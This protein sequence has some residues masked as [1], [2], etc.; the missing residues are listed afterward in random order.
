MEV[1]EIRNLTKKF[2][3]KTII[4]NMSLTVNEG[5]IYGF[6]GPNGSG[7]T[8]VIKCIMGLLK[9]TKGDVFVC[10]HSVKKNYEKAAELFGGII[11]NPE[12]YG[13]LKGKT[14]LKVFSTLYPNVTAERIEE[15]GKL[16]GLEGRL[17][18]P[19]KK[20]SLGMRQRLGLAL[21]LVHN[22]KLLILDEPT[23]GLDPKGVKE[24]R[25]ILKKLAK[26][27]TAIFISSHLL[28]EM[29]L[30]CDKVCIIDK[31]KIIDIKDLTK[32]GAEGVD[33]FTGVEVFEYVYETSND[34]K[35]YELAVLKGINASK[36]DGQRCIIHTSKENAA[37][38][39]KYLVDQGIHVYLMMIKSKTLEE[40]YMET[41]ES[42]RGGVK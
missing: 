12:M 24:L 14:N 2:G 1:L 8:T 6:L 11:E 10:G 27:G 5:E 22:P 25:D 23:N 9:M 34:E 4:D 29:E 31:G 20:Y 26:Q 35:T 39:T 7:K 30:M 18:E 32:A 37:K 13:A 36:G 33:A 21:S 28:S 3:K 42:K 16:V 38:F 40:L 17:N 19:I 41:T 15:I